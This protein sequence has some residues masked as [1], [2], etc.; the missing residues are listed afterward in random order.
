MGNITETYGRNAGK[1]W[2]IINKQGPQTP[3]KLMKTTGLPKEDF[4]TAIG[5]LAKENKIYFDNN[6]YNIGETNWNNYI[7]EN[8]GKV[9]NILN[10]CQEIDA[11]YIPKLAGVPW[12][13]AFYAIGWLAKEGKI[14]GKKVT[15]KKPQIVYKLK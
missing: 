6:T 3:T 7:G 1:I 12:E 15:P 13:E 2:H 14:T 4:Y 9:W 8:A 5:W 10:T 11:T